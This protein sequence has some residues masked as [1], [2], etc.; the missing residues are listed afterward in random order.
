MQVIITQ[1]NGL[2]IGQSVFSFVE[3]NSARASLGPS[4]LGYRL[5]CLHAFVMYIKYAHAQDK[6]YSVR[7]KTSV[8]AREVEPISSNLKA[9]MNG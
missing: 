6:Q 5:R 8:C 9:H 7:A 3:S 2:L 4:L 1:T